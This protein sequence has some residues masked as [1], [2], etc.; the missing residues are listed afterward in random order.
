MEKDEKTMRI[1][2]VLL[3]PSTQ[4]HTEEKTKVKVKPTTEQWQQSRW[5][6][7]HSC[8]IINPSLAIFMTRPYNIKS[9]SVRYVPCIKSPC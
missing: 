9:S 6:Y 7:I 2:Q 3:L 5:S 1:V 8:N 4:Q